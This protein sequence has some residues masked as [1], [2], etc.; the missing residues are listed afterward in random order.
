MATTEI[1]DRISINSKICHGKPC[2]KGTRIMVYQILDLLASG[3]PAEEIM[4]QDYF[5][6]L[7]REDI[8]ACIAFANQLVKD[9]DIY[10]Y[11]LQKVG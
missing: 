4:S 9:E 5:P 2:I 7:V 3:V 1:S 11:E 10:F 8:L 6:D